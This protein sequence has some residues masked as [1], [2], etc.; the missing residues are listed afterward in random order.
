MKLKFKLNRSFFIYWEAKTDQ[1]EQS[2]SLLSPT[3][4]REIKHPLLSQLDLFYHL[5]SFTNYCRNQCRIRLITRI[6]AIGMT[7]CLNEK[8]GLRL[9]ESSAN[10]SN[11]NCNVL[12]TK[13]DTKRPFPGAAAA[14]TAAEVERSLRTENGLGQTNTNEN[15][16]T[17]QTSGPRVNATKN[18]RSTRDTLAVTQTRLVSNCRIQL[19]L[20]LSWFLDHFQKLAV[21][22]HISFFELML[23]RNRGLFNL[24]LLK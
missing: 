7:P 23:Q 5:Y 1:I 24:L 9:Q 21:F 4:N 15:Q 13:A 3:D 17:K 10:C 19:D 12:A 2:T 20:C 6:P 16:N 18:C 11:T 22:S 8:W 14:D